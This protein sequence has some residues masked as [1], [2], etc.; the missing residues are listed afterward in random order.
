MKQ[1]IKRIK[2]ISIEAQPNYA[3]CIMNYELMFEDYGAAQLCIMHYELMFEDYG[4][5][6]LCIMHY[7]L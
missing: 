7:E 6:Q 3:L 1:R 5:A 2:R 4:A